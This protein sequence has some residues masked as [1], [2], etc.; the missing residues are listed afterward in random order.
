MNV[1]ELTDYAVVVRYGEEFYFPSLE[2]TKEA[3][4]IAEKVKDFV[5]NKLE[6]AGFSQTINVTK[7]GVRNDK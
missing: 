5:L 7:L 6:V 4:E 1:V 3:I 2:E